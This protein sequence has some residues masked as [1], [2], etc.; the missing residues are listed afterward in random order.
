MD[1]RMDRGGVSTFK[2]ELWITRDLGTASSLASIN[3][4]WLFGFPKGFWEKVSQ[5]FCYS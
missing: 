5:G 4:D 2:L 3:T 1:Q